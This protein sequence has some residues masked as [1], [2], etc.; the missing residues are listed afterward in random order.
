LNNLIQK[1]IDKCFTIYTLL[2]PAGEENM[3]AGNLEGSLSSIDLS[4]GAELSPRLSG[5]LSG[6]QISSE[7]LPDNP[8][9]MSFEALSGRKAAPSTNFQEVKASREEELKKL[10]DEG[11]KL[12]QQI[13]KLKNSHMSVKGI[14]K[15]A[16]LA[17]IIACGLITAA[18]G[19]FGAPV[20]CCIV[21]GVLV[22]ILAGVAVSF[23]LHKGNCDRQT[24][25]SLLERARD[26]G[27]GAKKANEGLMG[28][29]GSLEVMTKEVAQQKAVM[30]EQVTTIGQQQ[31]LVA[32][33]GTQIEQLEQQNINLERN[34]NEAQK[35][36]GAAE[37]QITEIQ[38]KTSEL[39]SD[40]TRVKEE[41]VGKE[42]EIKELKNINTEQAAE[43]QNQATAMQT[44]VTQQREMVANLERTMNENQERLSMAL[45]VVKQG[46]GEM[47]GQVEGVISCV[48]KNF[49]E[50]KEKLIE[51]ADA[52]SGCRTMQDFTD[53]QKHIGETIMQ[54]VVKLGTMQEEVIGGLMAL[55]TKMQKQ[56]RE[57]E[58]AITIS[59][60]NHKEASDK[61]QLLQK[62]C[63]DTEAKLAECKRKAE[64]ALETATRLNNGKPTR[65]TSQ[66][67]RNA[68]QNA[69]TLQR[70][71]ARLESH[72]KSINENLGEARKQEAAI[73]ATITE[74]QSKQSQLQS[75]CET[76]QQQ[77]QA[78]DKS[79]GQLF[80]QATTIGTNLS[81]IM[82]GVDQV[83][84]NLGT[85]VDGI[86]SATSRWSNLGAM[87]GAGVGGVAA[88]VLGLGTVATGGA[89]AGMAAVGAAAFTALGGANYVN[90]FSE[91]VASA[92][93]KVISLAT[94]VGSIIGRA[95]SKITQ[96]KNSITNL[97]SN[98]S[99]LD[100][101]V[102]KISQPQNQ[103]EFGYITTGRFN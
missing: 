6:P 48:Q 18:T 12:D 96:L 89:A 43:L 38:S 87:V 39:Q 66:L 58:G 68:M 90:G 54:S 74:L 22:G 80:T 83:S 73:R 69:Q 61:I 37:L 53:K 41:I 85:I 30:E 55:Q 33:Q 49:D 56:Q 70:R 81:V 77:N 2:S 71:A 59:Q 7:R 63:Q 4:Q 9:I 23:A 36:K 8:S 35:A 34:L 42:R 14:V 57:I 24:Q 76:L 65:Q 32:K 47:Q 19:G 62:N 45:E 98:I 51:A 75:N 1:I 26:L 16:L 79:N 94:S 3:R 44:F 93:K 20:A 40:L 100:S 84:S 86:G 99:E 10:Q 11:G 52:L 29:Y 91:F 103:P 88:V 82:E 92:G 15:R 50:V 67:I 95:T 60:Q 13:D 27:E 31:Q 78:L 5:R 46:N 28:A 17:A 25:I 21:V 64:A 101:S 102:K 72:L 97:E